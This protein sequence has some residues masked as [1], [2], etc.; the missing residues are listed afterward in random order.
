MELLNKILTFVVTVAY[1][2]LQIIINE[3]R[4]NELIPFLFKLRRST[5]FSPGPLSTCPFFPL[6]FFSCEDAVIK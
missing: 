4:M 3:I 2:H 5:S 6:F 1:A